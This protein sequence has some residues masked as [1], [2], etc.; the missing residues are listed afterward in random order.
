MRGR[1]FGESPAYLLCE[2]GFSVKA[3]PGGGLLGPGAADPGQ[4]SGKSLSVKDRE[5]IG[6][7]AADSGCFLVKA[8]W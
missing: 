8:L 2:G 7:G 6:P 3:Q 5:L 4:L 1:V